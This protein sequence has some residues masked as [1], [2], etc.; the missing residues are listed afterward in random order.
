M[1]EARAP[2]YL[3]TPKGR[4]AL[5]AAADWGARGC[6][7]MPWPS[8]MGVM[9]GE[10]GPYTRGRPGYNIIRHRPVF[11]VDRA[12][13]DALR[14]LSDKLGFEQGKRNHH[15]LWGDDE[16]DE[17]SETVFHYMDAKYVLGDGFSM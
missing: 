14:R 16:R 12:A 10:Q 2:V 11:T 8:P 6:G 5:I 4:V 15:S 1:A 13:F 9:A 3:D 17:D 7:D